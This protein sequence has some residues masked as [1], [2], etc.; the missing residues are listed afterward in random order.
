MGTGGRVT[1]WGGVALA[2]ALQGLG[3]PHCVF[4]RVWPRSE[5]GRL[6]PRPILCGPSHPRPALP[7]ERTDT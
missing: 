4:Y 2:L 5:L 7:R 6:E 3:A 1:A